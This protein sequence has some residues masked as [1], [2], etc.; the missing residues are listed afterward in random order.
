MHQC[1]WSGFSGSSVRDESGKT[2]C[3]LTAMTMA[4]VIP[5]YAGH[6]A[7]AWCQF[8][9]TPLTVNYQPLAQ[10]NL[11][12][13]FF[14]AVSGADSAGMNYGADIFLNNDSHV[15]DYGNDLL[16]GFRTTTLYNETTLSWQFW[17]NTFIDAGWFA[18]AAQTQP[19]KKTRNG[20]S[21][22]GCE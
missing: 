10:W 14:T 19:I 22:L 18:E 21:V 1:I 8:C 2:I 7:P 16:R 3:I 6:C 4:A 13:V 20:S 17:H 9:R 15:Q 5:I 11:S 12:N